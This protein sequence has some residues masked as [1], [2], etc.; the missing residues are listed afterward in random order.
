MPEDPAPLP[1]LTPA[2]VEDTLRLSQAWLAARGH[3]EDPC[4]ACGPSLAPPR[5]RNDGAHVSCPADH[6]IAACPACRLLLAAVRHSVSPPDLRAE[7][8]RLTAEGATVSA[9]DARAEVRALVREINHDTW[10]RRLVRVAHE[11][12]ALRATGQPIPAALDATWRTTLD[13]LRTLTADE[14]TP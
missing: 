4:P 7:I 10:T 11:R 3:G 13:Q 14:P 8:A 6:D 5:P 9:A 12:D 1:F 2:E